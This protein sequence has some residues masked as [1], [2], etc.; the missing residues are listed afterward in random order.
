MLQHPDGGGS[1]PPAPDR[2]DYRSIAR[3]FSVWGWRFDVNRPTIEFLE[4]RDVT[5]HGLTLH[6]TGQVSLEVPADCGTGSNGSR[7]VHVDLGPS[8]P[9]D[10]PGG[11]DATPAYGHSATVELAPLHGGR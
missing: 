8:M 5:C 6:G 1:P 10:A 3:S 9:T 7:I 2:F 4:L 11:A